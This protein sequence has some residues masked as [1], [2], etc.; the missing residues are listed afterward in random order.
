MPA[1]ILTALET[2][3]AHTV[4]TYNPFLIDI[5]GS[6]VVQVLFWWIPSTVFVYLDSIAPDFSEKHKIQ[7]AP[8]QPTRQEIIH[9]A[10]VSL[11]NQ[12]IAIA[13][14]IFLTYVGILSGDTEPKLRVVSTFPSLS[15]LT[16]DVIFCILAREV[17]FYY[18]HR[19]LHYP[20]LYKRIHKIHHKFTAPVAFSSQYAHPVE[21]IFG[22]ALPIALPPM[23][24]RT[25][26][27]TMWVFLASQLLETSMV[28]SGYDFLGGVARKHDRHHE[29]FNVWYGGI[30]ILDWLHG[31]GE[32]ED[33][34][35]GRK[36]D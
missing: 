11:R 8:K 10:V 34:L 14:H 2:Q 21:H 12:A 32:S 30:G 6:L 17:L 27:L 36:K 26:V 23:L 24:L 35:K 20:P 3:W 4:T 19:L 33:R 15:E 31:T 7:P 25:H 1:F 18:S 9:C 16:R 13:L 29:S 5:V 22:N 28:H